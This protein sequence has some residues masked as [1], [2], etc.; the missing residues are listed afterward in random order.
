MHSQS[1]GNSPQDHVVVGLVGCLV[2]VSFGLFFWF[3]FFSFLFLV[4][5][6]VAFF[7]FVLVVQFF[8][9][10]CLFFLSVGWLICA[11]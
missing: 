10:V 1:V 9:L 3:G 2:L 7:Y 4:V 11:G 5:V 8:G 6:P